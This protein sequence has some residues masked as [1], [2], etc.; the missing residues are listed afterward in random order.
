MVMGSH[1][2]FDFQEYLEAKRLVDLRCLNRR[3]LSAFRSRIEALSDPTV[4]D[5]GTGTGLMIRKLAGMHLKGMA[6]IIGVDLDEESCRAARVLIEDD[7]VRIG[8]RM[9]E[10]RPVQEETGSGDTLYALRESGSLCVEMR[11]GDVLAPGTPWLPGRMCFD[12]VTANA[13]IDLMPLNDTLSLV[14]RLLKPGGLLYA[15]IN[16]DGITTLLPPGDDDDFESK[17]LDIYN[18]SMEMRRVRGKV[19]G[20]S[21]TGSRLYGAL[22][23]QGFTIVEWG[24]SDWVVVPKAGRYRRGEKPFLRAILQMIY[25]EGRLSRDLEQERLDR[26]YAERLGAL[27]E[28]VAALSLMN[29]QVDVLARKE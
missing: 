19:T 7:L 11:V 13:F 24:S 8:F 3:V 15:T 27:K 1:A 20:G 22:L 18:R 10:R 17:L 21:R 2:V 25:E 12:A 5:L 9:E 14:C 16:Y 23:E 4:V 26:W 28:R 29:H 6:R